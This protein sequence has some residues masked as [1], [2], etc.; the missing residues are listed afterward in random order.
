MNA[1]PET[2]Y[3]NRFIRVTGRTNLSV[4]VQLKQMALCT[5]PF[6]QLP[7]PRR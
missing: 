7:V 6:S 2:D 1:V 5:G 3:A 4:T